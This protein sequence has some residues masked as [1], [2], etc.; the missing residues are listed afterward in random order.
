MLCPIEDRLCGFGVAVDRYA[1]EVHKW[2][3]ALVVRKVRTQQTL[4]LDLPPS[5]S[6]EQWQD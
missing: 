5:R 1:G 4:M 2:N 6:L 3:T